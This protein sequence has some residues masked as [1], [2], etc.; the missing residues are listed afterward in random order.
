MP[1]LARTG[2]LAPPEPILGALYAVFVVFSTGL[3]FCAV[4][5]ADAAAADAVAFL[6]C[7]VKL[8]VF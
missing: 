8:F 2:T 1:L 6:R 3:P 4:V 5:A 7:K